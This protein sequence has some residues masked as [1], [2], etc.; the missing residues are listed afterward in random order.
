[1]ADFTSP[2][3]EQLQAGVKAMREAIDAGERVA[4]HCGGGLGRTGTLMACYLV[5]RGASADAAIA[6][7]RRM[8]P[9]SIETR[10][11]EQAVRDYSGPT[12][13]T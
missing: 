8:R 3:P 1:V 11:Q 2:S 9:G 10:E 4:V 5:A 12:K 13:A 6:H 7:V